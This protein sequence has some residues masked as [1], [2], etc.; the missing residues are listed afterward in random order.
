[1]LYEVIT[2][3]VVLLDVLMSGYSIIA[4]GTWGVASTLI[5]LAV[6]RLGLSSTIL[7]LPMAL[8]R[9]NFV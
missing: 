6:T 5:V 9:N 2:P 7:A 4:A 3:L 8:Y 1:M